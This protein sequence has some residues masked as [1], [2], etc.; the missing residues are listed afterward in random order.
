MME[1]EAHPGRLLFRFTVGLVE[2]VG[3]GLVTSLRVFEETRPRADDDF[4][5]T[6]PPVRPRHV[7]IGAAAAAP[8][9]LSRRLARRRRAPRPSP[10][11]P[12]RRTG[13]RARRL[14][15]RAPGVARARRGLDS[16]RARVS[17]RRARVTAQLASWAELGRREEHGGRALAREALNGYYEI[18]LARVADSRELKQLVA[19]QS[20]G[21]AVSAVT[22]L[23]DG[24]ARADDAVESV[25]R[26]LLRRS[27]G[28]G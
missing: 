22:G 7:F 10:G 8:A 28:R 24:S 12:L 11:E 19:E 21:L 25:A 6:L 4:P 20:E 26:R 13:G 3:E 1:G 9:W 2:L 17:A 15:A 18:A 23:R 5:E 14:L 27:G 16:L